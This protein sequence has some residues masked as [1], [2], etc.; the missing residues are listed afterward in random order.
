MGQNKKITILFT[1]VGRRVE[2]VQQ[3]KKAAQSLSAR[4]WLIGADLSADAPALFYCNEQVSVCRIHDEAYI[5]Q[6]LSICKEK[7]VDLV[8]P[9]ID[10]DLLLLA[11]NRQLFEEAGCRVLIS[12]PDKISICRDK[13]YTSDFFVRCGLKAPMPVDRAEDYSQGFPAFIKPK[14]GSSSIDAYR[15]DN[16]EDLAVYAAKIK[17]YIIQ[18]FIDGREYTIDVFCDFDGNPIY[19]TPRERIAVRSGEVLKTQIVQDEVMI[20]ECRKIIREFKPCGPITVQL[21]RQKKSNE[22]Y[23][24]EINPRFGGGAPLSMKAGADAAGML[25][26]LLQGETL[27][28]LDRAAK[29]RAVYSRFDQSICIPGENG[30]CGA[31]TLQ[32]AGQYCED[33]QAVIFDLDDTLYP[34]KEYVRSGYR[35]IAQILPEVSDAYEKLWTAFEKGQNAIDQVLLDEGIYTE[36]RKKE[37]LDCYRRQEPDIALLPEAEQLLETF[38]KSGKKIGILTDG[39]VEGQR[40]KIKALGLEKLA[41]EIII[42]DELAGKCGDV[43]RFRK[44]SDIG[45]RLMQLRLNVPFEQMVYIGDN[46]KKDFDAP[47]QL[48][49][50]AVWYRNREGLYWE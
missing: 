2:L 38:R 46:R 18:P 20:E 16:R 15:V 28:Y 13:R 5:P 42:T 4:L 48:G 14:D 10:T 26:R 50:K 49:M 19:I 8:I 37:C 21:I 12:A 36:E 29:E 41:D 17:D 34:E 32:Q 44:P 45:F 31:E 43:M 1:S 35:K 40:A 25:V 23:Y 24:I 30:P 47:L 27:S 7:E 6:L 39:R 9:T 3:F 22:N 33:M 11:R